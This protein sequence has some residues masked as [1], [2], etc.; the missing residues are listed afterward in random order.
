MIYRSSIY[1]AVIRIQLVFEGRNSSNLYCSIQLFRFRFARNCDATSYKSFHEADSS[2][3][4]VR[5]LAKKQSLLLLKTL[6][7][8]NLLITFYLDQRAISVEF[9]NFIFFCWVFRP[10]WLFYSFKFFEFLSISTSQMRFMTS[11]IRKE[12]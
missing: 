7:N 10:F 1:H 12:T 4:P 9:I 11:M 2:W 6:F 3:T 5:I 8:S